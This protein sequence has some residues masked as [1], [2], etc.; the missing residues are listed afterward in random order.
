MTE[1]DEYPPLPP[2]PVRPG[3]EPSAVDR[4]RPELSV[5]R[6]TT[7]GL[8][9][10]PEEEFAKD[11]R[12]GSASGS[13]DMKIKN[14][15]YEWFPHLLSPSGRCPKR[16]A[17]INWNLINMK[18]Q[19]VQMV[20]YPIGSDKIPEQILEPVFQDAFDSYLAHWTCNLHCD[21][22]TYG[23]EGIFGH[24][25]SYG[26]LNKSELRAALKQFAE[27]EECDWARNML[28]GFGEEP[29]WDEQ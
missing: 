28:R 29:C 4:R 10:H 16:Y 2:C 13:I 14:P 17:E 22:E 18:V 27:I 5:A 11:V 26:F 19:D 7:E 6:Q 24:L 1:Q 3:E 25:L 21:R 12:Y 9:K 8:T 23:P 15:A 20:F